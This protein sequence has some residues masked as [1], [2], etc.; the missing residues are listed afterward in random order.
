MPFCA[1]ALLG[2][3]ALSREQA[4]ALIEEAQALHDRLSRLRDGLVKVL[5]EDGGREP[6]R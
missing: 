3:P 2:S 6:S 1:S 5:A 4:M